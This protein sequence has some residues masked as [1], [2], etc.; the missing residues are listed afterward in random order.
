M[1]GVIRG[2]ASVSRNRVCDKCVCVTNAGVTNASSDMELYDA[3]FCRN[4]P[5]RYFLGPM[6][7][8]SM[9]FMPAMVT[10]T[11]LLRWPCKRGVG[12]RLPGSLITQG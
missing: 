1:H 6:G 3:C 9:L 4:F 7:S 12:L 5:R 8:R 2:V 11:R 10:A